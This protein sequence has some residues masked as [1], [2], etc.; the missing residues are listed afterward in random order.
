MALFFGR[1]ICSSVFPD[2]PVLFFGHIRTRVPN[3]PC[4]LHYRFCNVLHDDFF[5]TFGV[6]IITL[7]PIMLL[8]PFLLLFP[9]TERYHGRQTQRGDRVHPQSTTKQEA[10]E[11][12]REG[13]KKKKNQTIISSNQISSTI[14][15]TL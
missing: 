2:L 3:C 4:R 6:H 5:F 1:R 13:E 12:A 8:L 7:F 10:H 11:R 9:N 14:R 15:S